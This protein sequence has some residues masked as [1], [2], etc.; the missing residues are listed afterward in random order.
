MKG[1]MAANGNLCG[2]AWIACKWRFCGNF[3]DFMGQ[4]MSGEARPNLQMY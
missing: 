4:E 2:W 1:D 3:A